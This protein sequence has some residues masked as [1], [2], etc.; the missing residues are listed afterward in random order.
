MS[1]FRHTISILLL[2]I[3]ISGC[4]GTAMPPIPQEQPTAAPIGTP[5]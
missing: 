1:R 2:I 3:V 5:V 4:K